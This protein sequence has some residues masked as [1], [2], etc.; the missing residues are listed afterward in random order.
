MISQKKDRIIVALDTHDMRT[1]RHI[2]S[3]L[4]GMVSIYKIG[5]E[6]YT[7][8]GKEVV[9]EVHQSGAKVFLD[10]KFHDIPNTVASACRMAARLGV[11]MMNVHTTGGFQMM[12][13]AAEQ[14]DAEAR[15]LGIKP[16]ILLGVTV[17][18][19]LTEQEMKDEIGIERPLEQEVLHLATLAKRA[20]LN[21]VV[22]SSHEI[23]T[24]KKKL[25]DDFIVVTPGIRP[26]WYVTGSDQKRVVTPKMAFEL[27]ADY[28]VVGRPII[29]DPDP[30]KACEKV[31][32]EVR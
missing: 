6:L 15:R 30:A 20:G 22:A 25:G 4:K 19:S 17:L 32:E 14:T 3:S 11:F 26:A 12:K 7:A 8:F 9:K 13:W 1:L 2:L 16:P 21:G 29:Q 27:G 10:L 5:L 28:I 18:T 31:L 24:I 23:Q